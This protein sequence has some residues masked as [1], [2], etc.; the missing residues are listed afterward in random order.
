[1]IRKNNL[2]SA[3]LAFLLF[4]SS[5]ACLVE[6][7]FASDDHSHATQE[8]HSITHDEQHSHDCENSPNS[9]KK[10]H[11]PESECCPAL[12]AVKGTTG[13]S[14]SQP[15]KTVSILATASETFL[16][17]QTVISIRKFEFPPGFSPPE[18]FLL[19]HFTHAPPASL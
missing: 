4:F 12:I 15:D 3:A 18:I 16:S 8:S 19:T 5:S 14:F 11:G 9:E 10:E 17:T 7:A 1:M 13:D 2:F 6:C